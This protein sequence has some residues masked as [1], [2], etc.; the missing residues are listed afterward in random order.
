MYYIRGLQNVS[1]QL[2]N[3]TMNLFLKNILP[4]SLFI[5]F[6]LSLAS[7]DLINQDVGPFYHSYASIGISADTVQV[8]S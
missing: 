1:H 8:G 6:G 3:E 2:T 5:G 4:V 7:C